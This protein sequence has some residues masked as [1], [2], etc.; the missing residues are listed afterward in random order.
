MKNRDTNPMHAITEENPAPGTGRPLI[1]RFFLTIY[2]DL[3]LALVGTP[4]GV[5]NN[6]M[7]LAAKLIFVDQRKIKRFSNKLGSQPQDAGTAD[8]QSPRR[9]LASMINKLS[10]PGFGRVGIN[11]IFR[12][13]NVP[14]VPL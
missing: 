6:L 8:L 5:N 4:N 10:V 14:A 13:K 3:D 11:E 1:R 9:V 12:E 7:P 2:P